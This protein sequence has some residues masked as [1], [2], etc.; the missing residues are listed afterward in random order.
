MATQLQHPAYEIGAYD[1]ATKAR[2]AGEGR[3][4]IQGPRTQVEVDSLRLPFPS[5]TCDRIASP[6]PVEAEADDVVEPIVGGSDCGEQLADI[7]PLFRT[8]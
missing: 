1:A 7:G 5:Q 4:E 3:S 2:P 8:A 6:S